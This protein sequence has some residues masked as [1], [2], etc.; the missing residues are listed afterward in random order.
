MCSSCPAHVRLMCSSCAAHVQLMCGSCAAHVQLMCASCV[1]HVCLMCSSRAPHV[2]LTCSSC[3]VHVQLPAKNSLA[4]EWSQISWAY[5]QMWYG[6]YKDQWD[7]ELINCYA[8]FSSKIL[9]LN[10]SRWTA[11]YF[12]LAKKS[13]RNLTWFTT[14]FFLVRVGVWA[15]D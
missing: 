15:Q 9:P 14:P 13:T 8:S 10:S 2:Q 11:K 1:A 3:G 12:E 6:D 4:S 5:C 7:C